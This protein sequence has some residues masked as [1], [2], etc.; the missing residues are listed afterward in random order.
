MTVDPLLK[1]LLGLMQTFEESPDDEIDPHV[2]TRAL[3][4]ASHELQAV[5]EAGRREVREALARIAAE[6]GWDPSFVRTLPFAI[7]WD[8]PPAT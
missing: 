8:E 6:P 3:E 4:N 1:A 7:G 2:A 5:D